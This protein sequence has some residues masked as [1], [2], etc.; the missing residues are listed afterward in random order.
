MKLIVSIDISDKHFIKYKINDG[1]K[2]EL[3]CTIVCLDY[4]E[5]ILYRI[6]NS[7]TIRLRY[8]QYYHPHDLE[9]MISSFEHQYIGNEYEY[10]VKWFGV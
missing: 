5:G 8:Q 10:F 7:D 3:F 9:K 1:M 6:C 2:H 4:R